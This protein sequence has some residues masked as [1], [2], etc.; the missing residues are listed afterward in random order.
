MRTVLII[1]IFAQFLFS[2]SDYDSENASAELDSYF[3][4]QFPEDEPGG[5]V[6]V[7][8]GDE[9]IFEKGYGIADIET[10]EKITPNTV[11]NT[12]SI[13]KTFVSN[14]IL[15]LRQ[16]GKLSL[17][18][19]IDK[20]FPDFTNKE[21]SGKVKIVNFLSH[22][23]GIRDSRNVSEDPEFYLTANDAENFHPVTQNEALVF[24]PGQMFQYSNPAYNGLALIIEQLSGMK[25]QKFIKEKIFT[26]SGMPGSR[27]TD[28]AYP[29]EGVSHGYILQDGEFR[30]NDYGEV[31]TFCAAGNGGVWSSVRDL[32]NYELAIRN[33]VFL[34]R[35]TIAESRE[36]YRPQNWSSDQEPVIGYSWFIYEVNGMTQVGH[37]GSQGGFISDYV[38]F[39][40]K[41]LF[42]VLL[43]NT[44]KK[45]RD[46]RAE[47]LKI[48]TENSL[49]K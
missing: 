34:D 8:K 15:I 24:E 46:F 40:E 2:C 36:V 10:G 14:G 28:G 6:L 3:S 47:V 44:P 18:D 33:A 43:C 21:I 17:D 30:E 35:E 31:P 39:P 23:S 38:S 27:I 37:T 12:G 19:S 26:Q 29:D 13:S 32:A 45:I 42:Y 11:F 48:L 25:W 20:Y 16:E 9:I 49:M 7:M 41:E 4:G 5:A 22:T 1:L